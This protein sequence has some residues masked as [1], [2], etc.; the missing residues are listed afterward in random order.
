L[1]QPP[2]RRRH[3]ADLAVEN[4]L[5]PRFSIIGIYYQGVHPPEIYRRGVEGVLAQTFHDYEL[6]VY[7][8]GPL[9]HEVPEVAG[10]DGRPIKVRP[11]TVRHNDWGHSLRDL[12]IR[13]AA[14]DYIVLHNLD[15]VLH[16]TLLEKLEAESRRPAY[17]KNQQGQ[18]VD[19]DNI[20]IFP[21]LYHDMQR[22]MQTWLR[23]PKGS[24]A[25]M[26]FTGNPPVFGMIDCM[27]L[28]MKRGLWLAEG[29]WAD[30]SEASDGVMYPKLCAKYGYRN[31]H[32]VLGEHH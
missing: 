5:M 3:R 18:V 8:D 20:L 16:P 17:L 6:L 31:L 23:L 9:L 15:N 19:T 28:V 27:Q 4:A 7:H 12:G 22:Y 13:E 21:I 32:E 30:K 24:G 1:P 26:I 29:G 2:H 14:G 10:A 25:R 11:T